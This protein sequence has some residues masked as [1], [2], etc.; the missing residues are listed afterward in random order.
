[1]T[2]EQWRLAWEAY[3]T[4]VD[5][6]GDERHSV[7]SRLHTDPE[8]LD[9]VISMLEEAQINFEDTSMLPVPLNSS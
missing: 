8:V 7:L 2:D 5:L 4:T 3:A 9:Q 6:A 1:M